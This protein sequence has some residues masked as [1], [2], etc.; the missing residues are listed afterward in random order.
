MIYYL[1]LRHGSV[2]IIVAPFE[3]DAQ[4]AFIAC[5]QECDVVI[6]QDSDLV[7]YGVPFVLA[8]FSFSTMS[9]VAACLDLSK[10][11]PRPASFEVFRGACILAGGDCTSGLPGFG[12]KKSLALLKNFDSAEKLIESLQTSGELERIFQRKG[13][14]ISCQKFL[15]QF[16]GAVACFYYHPVYNLQLQTY[17]TLSV[18]DV[19]IHPL[20]TSPRFFHDFCQDISFQNQAHE[21]ANGIVDIATKKPWTELMSRCKSVIPHLQLLNNFVLRPADVPGAVIQAST[22]E[23]VKLLTKK[24]LKEWMF[25]RDI[26]IIGTFAELSTRYL[27]CRLFPHP[28]FDKTKGRKFEV[29]AMKKYLSAD[30]PLRKLSQDLSIPRTTYSL[31][32]IMT[33]DVYFKKVL[34]ST[35]L[36]VLV[37]G[38][39]SNYHE[40]GLSI[41]NTVMLWIG[42]MLQRSFY[43]ELTD[44]ETAA[45]STIKRISRMVD[46][47]S[48]LPESCA[49]GLSQLSEDNNQ[50]LHSQN[51][52]SS[53]YF[54]GNVESYFGVKKSIYNNTYSSSSIMCPGRNSDLQSCEQSKSKRS[55]RKKSDVYKVQVCLIEGQIVRQQCQCPNQYVLFMFVLFMFMINWSNVWH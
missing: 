10:L 7:A 8:K 51:E 43:M 37:L 55:K 19:D 47:S 28:I 50:D 35:I 42:N 34:L 4:L 5:N 31:E 2:D 20:G 53:M 38:G 17:Q 26:P 41:S 1:K 45:M 39:E 13:A 36:S 46:S 3:A 21:F 48:V 32:G 18:V 16:H 6:S 49:L 44:P 27:N 9:G 54:C 15:T 30:S 40:T 23:E 33:A 14:T 25:C 11:T 24:E 29:A 22:A 52:V 12:I